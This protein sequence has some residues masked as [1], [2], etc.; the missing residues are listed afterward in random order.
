MSVT[1]SRSLESLKAL[2]IS[3]MTT[4]VAAVPATGSSLRDETVKWQTPAGFQKNVGTYQPA[5]TSVDSIFGNIKQAPTVGLVE[6]AAATRADPTI[7]RER[8]VVLKSLRTLYMR[9][10]RLPISANAVAAS[11]SIDDAIVVMQAW[12]KEAPVPC[13]EEDDDGRVSLEVLTDGG[14]AI[15]AIDFLGKDHVAAYSI[16]D[17]DKIIA[18]GKLN[19]ASTTDVIRFFQKLNSVAA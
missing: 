1:A 19:T 2:A 8:D 12:P 7:T 13:L 15:A 6:E 9:S 5:S 16:V 18:A 10:L 3:G 14:V 17:R 4:F 11:T